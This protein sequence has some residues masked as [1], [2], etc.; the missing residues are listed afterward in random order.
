[1][2]IAILGN[3]GSG[4]LSLGLRL[5]K[6]LGLSLIHLDQHFWKPGW[7]EP[8]RAEFEKIHNRLCDQGQWIIEG[9][10]VRNAEYETLI[11][12]SI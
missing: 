3:A 1:M 7:V 6:L 9:M 5:H 10:S 4:K 2:K 12:S 11:L 8:E